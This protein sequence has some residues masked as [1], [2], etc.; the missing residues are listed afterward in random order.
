MPAV[1]PPPCSL[2]PS[3]LITRAATHC[4]STNQKQCGSQHYAHEATHSTRAHLLTERALLLGLVAAR[5]PSA[6]PPGARR[7][8]LMHSCVPLPTAASAA[9]VSIESLLPSPSL[10]SPAAFLLQLLP[11]CRLAPARILQEAHCRRLRSP[12][13]PPCPPFLIYFLTMLL[14]AASHQQCRGTPAA[15]PSFCESGIPRKL[16]GVN[17]EL[18]D[19]SNGTCAPSCVSRPTAPNPP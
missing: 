14:R 13:C 11:S 16:W 12:P 1:L 4:H 7:P 3:L 17:S 6:T 15:H 10:L 18:R 9:S 8:A 19:E 2:R 5:L